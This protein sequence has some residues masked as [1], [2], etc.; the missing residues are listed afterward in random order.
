MQSAVD[1][2][3]AVAVLDGLAEL[4]EDRGAGLERRRGVAAEED[5][6]RDG[7]VEVV[8]DDAGTA[9]RSLG[10]VIGDS[11]DAAVVAEERQDARLSLGGA[12]EL[13]A[14]FLRRGLR[15]EVRPD[16]TAD[17]GH[18]L[19]LRQAV[20]VAGSPFEELA[21]HEV[22]E[23]RARYARWRA[24]SWLFCECPSTLDA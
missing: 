24:G 17:P 4:L 11:Q 7:V 20:L 21:E 5:V 13:V 14:T 15:D 19:V 9:C 6:E 8:E 23:A 22:A 12:A 3:L 18:A 1:D 16:A 2:A 10:V